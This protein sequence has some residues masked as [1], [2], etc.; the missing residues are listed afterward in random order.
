MV[1]CTDSSIEN[2]SL[3]LV[4]CNLSNLLIP[5]EGTSEEECPAISLDIIMSFAA[6]QLVVLGLAVLVNIVI[7]MAWSR[8]RR[9]KVAQTRSSP[10]A[11]VFVSPPS[12]SDASHDTL[13]ETGRVD[14]ST[15][16][17]QDTP[18]SQT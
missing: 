14:T 7:L 17:N 1:S 5:D 12:Y 18:T 16:T 11:A 13:L 4:I 10:G 9:Q 2:T 6:V 3:Q 15:F 8:W